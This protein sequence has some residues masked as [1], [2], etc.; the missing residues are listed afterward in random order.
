ML[1]DT[2]AHVA[3]NMAGTMSQC[4]RKK[5]P[6]VVKIRGAHPMQERAVLALEATATPVLVTDHMRQRL[7]MHHRSR[8]PVALLHERRNLCDNSIM[9]CAWFNRGGLLASPKPLL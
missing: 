1:L 4:V 6:E 9:R 2:K 8:Q 3:V 5:Q 7:P